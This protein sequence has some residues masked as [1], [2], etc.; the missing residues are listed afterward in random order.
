MEFSIF[1]WVN[2]LTK[3]SSM[4]ATNHPSWKKIHNSSLASYCENIFFIV[5]IVLLYIYR[6]WVL[7]HLSFFEETGSKC[8]WLFNLI[9]IILGCYIIYDFIFDASFVDD[10][11]IIIIVLNVLEFG[12]FVYYFGK[13]SDYF[14]K[15]ISLL[16][17][18]PFNMGAI[19]FLVIV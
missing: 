18:I 17:C 8:I 3:L 2:V 13:T 7:C 5:F 16:N 10:A 9:F 6:V 1:L 11:I 19:L 12:Y 14:I 15:K 4:Y